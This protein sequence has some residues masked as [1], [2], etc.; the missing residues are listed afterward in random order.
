MSITRGMTVQLVSLAVNA[1]RD[2]LQQP[3]K[4]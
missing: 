3:T 2:P 4:R 1:A